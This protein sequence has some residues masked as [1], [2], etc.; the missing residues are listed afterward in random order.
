MSPLC[1]HVD[2]SP[3]GSSVHGILQ[4]RIQEWIT[5][6]FSKGSSW[7]R[8]QTLVSCISGRFFTIWATKDAPKKYYIPIK[9]AEIKHNDRSFPSGLVV[10]AL[11]HRGHRFKPWSGKISHASEQLSPCNYWAHALD[12]AGHSY[13]SLH[14]LEP[15]LYNKISHCNKK[16]VHHR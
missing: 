8:D 5:I 11:Q 4:A 9:I 7:P 3:P 14:A 2:N 16:P 6:P 10:N 12:P 13:Q 1:N 15:A